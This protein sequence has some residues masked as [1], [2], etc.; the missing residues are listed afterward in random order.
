MAATTKRVTFTKTRTFTFTV[1]I[2]NYA[3]V[4]DAD[5]LAAAKLPNGYCSLGELLAGSSANNGSI[6]NPD[7]VGGAASSAWSVS[8]TGTP[9]EPYYTWTASTLL[10]VGTR[11]SP[12]TP[13]SKLYTATA[14]TT[15]TTEPVWPTTVGGTVTN[16]TVTFT[17]IAK[18]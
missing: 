9:I 8:G 1:D 4:L 14:G 15:G 10:A 17:C 16:G 11:V 7:T 6:T 3:S 12:T 18:F 5:V 2:P 13:T